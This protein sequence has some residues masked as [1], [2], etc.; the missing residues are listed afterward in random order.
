VRDEVTQARGALLL[1]AAQLDELMPWAWAAMS[2]GK[3]DCGPPET[4]SCNSEATFVSAAADLEPW[5]E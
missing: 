5:A 1:P 2:T 3:F 4:G